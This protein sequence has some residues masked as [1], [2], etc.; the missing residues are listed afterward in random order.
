MPF[1]LPI[2]MPQ[3]RQ[4]TSG[5]DVVPLLA[6]GARCGRGGRRAFVPLNTAYLDVSRR[7][8][9]RAGHS[10]WGVS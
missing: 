10:N 4:R 8:A 9:P 5:Q 2:G 7:G 1:E 6:D 3:Q